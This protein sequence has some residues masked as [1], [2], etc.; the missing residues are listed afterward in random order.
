MAMS[1][2]RVECKHAS[3][4]VGGM[5]VH[6]SKS[7]LRILAKWMRWSVCWWRSALCLCVFLYK[8]T[9]AL[10]SSQLV[11]VCWWWWWWWCFWLCSIEL[12]AYNI[13]NCHSHSCYNNT[14]PIRVKIKLIGLSNSSRCVRICFES[15]A[16]SIIFLH[17]RTMGQ[18]HTTLTFHRMRARVRLCVCE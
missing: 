1:G 5:V 9:A 17:A 8:S 12:S 7:A 18:T 6:V 2:C 16:C 3:V 14:V 15:N 13:P 11:I 10:N 4:W